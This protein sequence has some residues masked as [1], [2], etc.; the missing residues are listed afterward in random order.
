M[1]KREPLAEKR[2]KVL[3]AGAEMWPYASVGGLS[4]VMYHLPK[5]L[6]NL[7]VD[8][9]VFMPKY[10]KISTE[11]HKFKTVLKGLKVPT[12]ESADDFI[13]CNVLSSQLPRGSLVYFLENKEYFELRSNEYGYSDDY[14]RWGLLQRGLLEFLKEYKKWTPDI[15][16]SNDW[17]AG[18]IANYF[19]QEY[20][21]EEKLKLIKTI[22][23]IHNIRF[24]A[25]YDHKFVSEMDYDAGQ[26]TPPSIL[27]E[28]FL[29]LNS[30]RRGIM[31]NDAV[32]T[33][34]PTYS[35]EILT[36]EFGEG[37]DPLL[38]E[39]RSKVSGVLN[40]IDINDFDPKTDPV[41]YKNFRSGEWIKRK[42][43]KTFLQ[44][45]FGLTKDPNTPLF[46]MSYRLTGQKG[47]DLITNIIELV[48]T[49]FN[50][51]LIVNGDGD[52]GY[53]SYFKELSEKYPS[54]VGINLM[55]DEKLPR[56]LFAGADLLLHPS[57]FEP[58]GIV[59]LEAMRYGCVP[60]VREIGGLADTVFDRENG[61]TFKNFRSESL[62]M[63]IARAV[64][65]FRY[66]SLFQ[67][68]QASCMKQDYSW[69]ASAD[70]YLRLYKNLVSG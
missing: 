60:I 66:P 21:K 38:N 16:H 18:F 35:K 15:L 39:V 2:L 69:K 7:G 63:T 52:A 12:S 62:L 44:E 36:K 6:M 20:F 17:Q 4:R 56:Q 67:K 11:E 61:F 23:T 64:S 9:R 29:K 27:S 48:L 45:K 1:I 54:Q 14:T 46:A 24:Q 59:Q 19:K 26:S 43:N 53:K 22:F 5:A 8:A 32:T 3:F 57:K 51:Q 55:W 50:A 42:E 58:C 49:E 25:Q 41:L 10:G 68:I 47:L 30:M 70:S 13:E 40:G 34:S 31:Y 65:V 28:D 33:V 37:L